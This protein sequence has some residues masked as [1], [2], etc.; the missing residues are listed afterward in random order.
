MM[1]FKSIPLTS[2]SRENVLIQ[3]QYEDT[4][5]AAYLKARKALMVAL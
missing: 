1:T 5:Q 2:K 3:K 4:A